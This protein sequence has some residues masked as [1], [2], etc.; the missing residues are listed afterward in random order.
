MYES[1]PFGEA[2]GGPVPVAVETFQALRQRQTSEGMAAD[3]ENPSRVNLL[4]WDGK[5]APTGCSRP[6]GT[7]R[8]DAA[9]TA[10]ATPTAVAAGPAGVAVRPRCCWPIPDERPGRAA[11]HR[12]RGLPRP[13]RPARRRSCSATVA[14]AAVPAI[15]CSAAVD[16]VDT[17]DLRRR[18]TMFLTYC[19]AGDTRNRGRRMH[20]FA[21]V[22]R[23][24]GVAAAEPARLP[25]ICRW[26]SSSPRPST[27]GGAAA[28]GAA[29]DA[30]RPAA[31][32]PAER[33]S[34]YAH[35]VAAVCATL[36]AATDQDLRRAQRLAQAGPPAEAVGLEPFT[37]TV[38][39]RRAEGGG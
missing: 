19:T 33:R 20:A 15:R 31:R 23:A 39:P 38:P 11:R 26:C 30:D 32:R 29:P 8:I 1:G 37:L 34:P 27:R 5:G 2:S 17:F 36:P 14:V 35:A 10:S 21:A 28:A 25:T 18:R 9:M 24:A 16:Y 6:D 22:Y 3:A 7:A 12:R 13:R 4:N